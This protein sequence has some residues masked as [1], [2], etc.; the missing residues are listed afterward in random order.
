MKILI[1]LNSLI[2]SFAFSVFAQIGNLP[3]GMGMPQYSGLPV[4]VNP[5]AGRAAYEELQKRLA[6]LQGPEGK[7]YFCVIEG[8]T[9]CIWDISGISG[10]VLEVTDDGILLNRFSQ[11]NVLLTNYSKVVVD[12]QHIN[13]FAKNVGVYSYQSVSGGISTI[14]K[15]DCGK[16]VLPSQEFLEQ[17][18]NLVRTAIATNPFAIRNQSIV[19]KQEKAKQKARD[20]NYKAQANA[21]HVLEPEATNGDAS[22][23][24][25]LGMH[26]LNGQGCET[27]Q[28]QGIYW[29]QKAAAQGDLR[30][31]KKLEQLKER[32]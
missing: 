15:Y 10:R 6:I 20:E 27:N 1:L 5:N 19:E 32:N 24:C 22:A 29:L 9:N 28:E 8:V 11:N 7:N 13:C 21:I 23:Q 17:A 12:N 30:A 3:V 31:S 25:E 16:P 2:L 4:K 18:I 26:Y 14:P